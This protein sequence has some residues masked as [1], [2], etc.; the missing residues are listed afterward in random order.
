M[1][2]KSAQDDAMD[3]DDGPAPSV[4]PGKRKKALKRKASKELPREAKK[5]TQ[6]SAT[7]HWCMTAYPPEGVP[8]TSESAQKWFWE[9]TEGDSAWPLHY[10]V[11]QVERGQKEK[12]LHLQVYA[13]F[14]SRM[15]L[16]ALKKLPAGFDAP[17]ATDGNNFH[18][19]KRKGTPTQARAYCMKATGK[20]SDTF[21]FNSLPPAIMNA[22]DE[23]YR[24]IFVDVEAPGD[25]SVSFDSDLE[26]SLSEYSDGGGDDSEDDAASRFV[27]PRFTPHEDYDPTPPTQVISIDDD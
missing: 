14:E 20:V 3:L 1:E 24:P 17:V 13:E 26:G 8:L 23:D 15:R 9:V 2:K 4:L 19:E 6:E 5:A 21:M 11:A 16:T 7:Y 22:S 18:W 27:R 12:H 25:G 10:M